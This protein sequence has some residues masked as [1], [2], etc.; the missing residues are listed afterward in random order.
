MSVVVEQKSDTQLHLPL[1]ID[2]KNTNNKVVKCSCGLICGPR[3]LYFHHLEA[4]QSDN[5]HL[6][7]D[8]SLWPLRFLKTIPNIELS[9]RGCIARNSDYDKVKY[10]VIWLDRM[11]KD[12]KDLSFSQTFIDEALPKINSFI[13]NVPLQSTKDSSQPNS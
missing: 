11:Q 8:A 12:A 3:E 5:K 9:Q 7:R 2:G 13:I 4:T 6:P 10:I 1:L